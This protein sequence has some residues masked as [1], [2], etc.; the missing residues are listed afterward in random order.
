MAEKCQRPFAVVQT[1]DV[2]T[3]LLRDK[4]LE[5]LADALREAVERMDLALS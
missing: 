5:V 2:M 3:M 4:R 1:N